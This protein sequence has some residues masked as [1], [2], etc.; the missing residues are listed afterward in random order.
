M[1]RTGLDMSRGVAGSSS[2]RTT[3]RKLVGARGKG[4][5]VLIPGRGFETF[6]A[7]AAS[8]ISGPETP[9]KLGPR[10]ARPPAPRPEHGTTAVVQEKV[11]AEIAH[12]L[13]NFFHKLYYW[14]DYLKERPSRKTA[15]STA[16]QMLERTIKNLEDFLKVSLDYFHPTQLS[17]SRM[18][19]NELVEGLLFQV[20]SHLNGTPATVADGALRDIDGEVLV[21]PGHLSYA[22]EVTVRQLTKQLGDDS[23]V[24]VTIARS[25]RPDAAGIE[26]AFQVREPNEAS[27][28][29]RT[30]EA[31]VEWA[32]A[33]KFVAL[34]GGELQERSAP[35]GEKEIVL[36]LPLCA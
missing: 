11:L 26:V 20:R 24:T 29:F 16:A 22:F 23:R 21:D 5:G 7:M 12:E 35:A 1:S 27:P 13:G 6:A 4:D 10:A 17:F 31:G 8:K 18:T 28:L 9:Q 34:H 14:S 36:F 32:V 15:D 2:R 33:Q 19:V 25:G 3:V 30:A